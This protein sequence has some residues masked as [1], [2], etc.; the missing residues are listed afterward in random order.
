M[1]S[2]NLSA[3]LMGIGLGDAVGAGYEYKSTAEVHAF[4]STWKELLAQPYHDHGL[5]KI[6][7]GEY[8]DDTQMSIGVIHALMKHQGR[9]PD[10]NAFADA[11]ADAYN[12]NPRSGY[13]E[14]LQ[15]AL[16]DAHNGADLRARIN[17]TASIK[18]G[19]AMR[20]VPIGALP[21]KAQVIRV[22]SANAQV[23]HNNPRGIASSVAVALAA[24][25]FFYGLGDP[26]GVFEYCINEIEPICGRSACHFRNISML[27][28]ACMRLLCGDKEYWPTEKGIPGCGMRT[29]GAVLFLINRYPDSAARVMAEAILLGGDTDS[30]AAIATG[31]IAGRVGIDDMPS[32]LLEGIENGSHGRTYLTNLGSS[33]ADYAKSLN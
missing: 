21:D 27:D 33:F 15:Q 3:A 22:A 2:N 29:V 18:N 7:G 31:I 10:V 5:G 1:L 14:F 25:Y 30:V 9:T 19:A 6:R 13:S 4:A 16:D 32:H 11:F 17:A 8:T 26:D 12:E 20:A 28:S 23:T 24:H